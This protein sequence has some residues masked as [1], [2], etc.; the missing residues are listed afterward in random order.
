MHTLDELLDRLRAFV[1]EQDTKVLLVVEVNDASNGLVVKSLD[2]LDEE[3]DDMFWLFVDDF[4]NAWEFADRVVYRVHERRELANAALAKENEPA[5]PPLPREA[6]D[7]SFAPTVRI[8]AAMAYARDLSPNL[9]EVRLVCAFFP[10]RIAGDP[11]SYRALVLELMAHEFPDP[12]CHH[13]RIL[14][15]DDA[16]RPALRDAPGLVRG[17]DSYAPL[18]A[19]PD[20]EAAVEAQAADPTAPIEVRMQ[21]L[22]TLAGIDYAHQRYPQALDKYK[23][24][25]SYYRATGRHALYALTLNGMGE[26]MARAQQPEAARRYFES[27]L[28]P[29]LHRL[30]QEDD[31]AHA[32]AVPVLLNI[33]LNLGNLYFNWQRWADAG[34]YYEVA[35]GIAHGMVLAPVKIMCLENIGVCHY[36]L[37]RHL[38]AVKAWEEGVVLARGIEAEEQ[39]RSLLARQREAYHTLHLADRRD[40]VIHELRQLDARSA[41]ARGA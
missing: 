34:A 1:T 40:A 30:G 18:L 7:R 25:G 37:G 19:P 16:A 36:A 4:T 8:R 5:W 13:M 27:A 33:N 35:K 12:W 28:T 21:S 9:D 22:L 3:A 10:A 29:A 41:Q 31:P 39:L 11:A 15:R 2:I 20:L 26:V 38:E 24:A 17:T 32:D 14:V 6:L 23:L